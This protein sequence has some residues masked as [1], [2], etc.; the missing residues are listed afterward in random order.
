MY[1]SRGTAPKPFHFKALAENGAYNAKRQ[2]ENQ[3]NNDAPY[4]LVVLH[5]LYCEFH[6]IIVLDLS[7]WYLCFLLSNRWYCRRLCWFCW[8][9]C[10]GVCA[11]VIARAEHTLKITR[12]QLMHS[13]RWQCTYMHSMHCCC[14]CL[15]CVCV[16]MFVL[17]CMC[18][19]VIL[20]K[21]NIYLALDGALVCM[22]AYV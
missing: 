10:C 22:C 13:S 12:Q 20:F 5:V 11:R 1:L 17:W 4:W 7:L 19:L 8:C 21:K 6:V 3:N 16:R 14:I 2:A 15:L 9:L 18:V